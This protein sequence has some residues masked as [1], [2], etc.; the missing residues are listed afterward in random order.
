MVALFC[1]NS[2]HWNCVCQNALPYI[3]L[4]SCGPQETFYMRFE[5]GRKQPLHSF[6]S[7]KATVRHQ[8][9]LQLTHIVTN[10]L[11][12][13]GMKQQPGHGSSSPSHS[14]TRCLF[15]SVLTGASCPSKSSVSSKWEAWKQWDT[16]VGSISSLRAPGHPSS[17]QFVLTLPYFLS[18]FLPNCQSCWLEDAA[19]HTEAITVY[20]LFNAIS[21]LSKVKS[22]QQIPH[23]IPFIYYC[24]Y[25]KYNN[26]I[27]Y[28]VVSLFYRWGDRS[29]KD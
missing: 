9:R 26:T 22:L 18:I 16:P 14:C 20:K 17:F 10:L 15:S 4:D 12:H 11:A 13:L 3:V 6:H 25:V 2:A 8:A 24:L 28:V 7:Q 23:S 21:Q 29:Q 19:C 1:V 27:N 5:G